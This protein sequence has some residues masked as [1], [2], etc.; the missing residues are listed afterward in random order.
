MEILIEFT[1]Y[2]LGLA[3]I[4]AFVNLIWRIIA[5]RSLSV[6]RSGLVASLLTVLFAV[7]GY[8]FNQGT[9]EHHAIKSY[10]TEF[11]VIDAG[12][13]DYI[14]YAKFTK[15]SKEPEKPETS[16]IY[17]VLHADHLFGAGGKALV[18]V[19]LP[20]PMVLQTS[21]PTLFDIDQET[22]ETAHIFKLR[23]SKFQG[24]LKT[25]YDLA[26]RLPTLPNGD[27]VCLRRD[28]KVEGDPPPT[29]LIQVTQ[30]T[31]APFCKAF[32]ALQ[33]ERQKLE[34]S[35]CKL[36]KKLETENF[37]GCRG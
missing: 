3:A 24:A 34:Q 31:P 15:C 11:S 14:D 18:D 5:K 12:L 21:Y 17:A 30:G 35:L 22:I 20:D 6:V 23:M 16:N 27:P 19:P 32:Y 26:T 2:A 28:G 10:K 9:D 4:F 13:R 36:R 33:C 29:N 37:G 25:A 1:K 7:G 8:L